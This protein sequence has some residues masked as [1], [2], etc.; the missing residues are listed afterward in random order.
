MSHCEPHDAI[1]QYCDFEFTVWLDD[2]DAN[3]GLSGTFDEIECAYC[4]QELT[5]V[6]KHD[7]FVKC[8]KG[9]EFEKKRII[10]QSIKEKRYNK[11]IVYNDNGKYGYNAVSTETR[12]CEYVRIG[13]IKCKLF[14]DEK[15][16]L[17]YIKSLSPEFLNSV[18][19]ANL[20][21]MKYVTFLDN[22]RK[23]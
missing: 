22:K 16:A 6:F 1:C 9:K 2:W 8:K 4:G 15:G 17:D 23:K 5:V 10:G 11:F 14:D 12:W 19:E 13:D 3:G 18:T 7:E 20:K 21:P